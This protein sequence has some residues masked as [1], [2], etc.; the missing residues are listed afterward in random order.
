MLVPLTLTV[1]SLLVVLICEHRSMHRGVVIFKPLASTGFVWGAWVAGISDPVSTALFVGLLLSWL[2]DVL[3]I[4]RGKRWFLA[5]LVV[6]LLGHV[7]FVSAFLLHGVTAGH[8]AAGAVV[9]IALAGPIGWWL[10]P[11]LEPRMR[12]P[13]IAYI[14]VISVMVATALGA[15]GAGATGWM[16]VAALAFFLSDL[17]VAIDRF[18]RASFTNRLWGLPLYYAA[19]WMFV[20]SLTR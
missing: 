3:L 13:V 8:T 5:G 6:F 4:P 17:S 11:R 16:P 9:A 1:I 10:L 15:Y 2:G 19:Q 18:V 12:R 7:G 14:V 20:L